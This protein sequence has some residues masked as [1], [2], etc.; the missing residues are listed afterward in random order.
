MVIRN[1][2]KVE[3]GRQRIYK[4]AAKNN[5][6]SITSATN[7]VAIDCGKDSDFAKKVLKELILLGIFVRMPFV[8]PQD[9]CIRVSVG[10]KRDLDRFEK[11]L[12]SA[13]ERASK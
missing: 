8:F 13:L 10:K 11:A 7:F 6:K 1:G 3:N 5:L 2:G 9:R 12:P 4:I